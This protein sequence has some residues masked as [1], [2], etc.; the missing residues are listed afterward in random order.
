MRKY[1]EEEENVFSILFST[2]QPNTRKYFLEHF[3]IMQPN[4]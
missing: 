4:T 3:S 1:E 2:T